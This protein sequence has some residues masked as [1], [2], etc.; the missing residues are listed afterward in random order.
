M[1]EEISIDFW[2]KP[3][4]S[5]FCWC[6]ARNCCSCS[7]S[8]PDS[9]R[10]CSSVSD[11]LDTARS[12]VSLMS[13][14]TPIS[15]GLRKPLGLA[16]S[17]GAGPSKR[18]A[19]RSAG[20]VQAFTACGAGA[21]GLPR[22]GDCIRK[23]TACIHGAGLGSAMLLGSWTSFRGEAGG[24]LRLPGSEAHES[25]TKAPFFE[26]F[27]A[28]IAVAKGRD[29]HDVGPQGKVAPLPLHAIILVEA[30]EDS[31]SKPFE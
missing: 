13:S 19:G 17:L 14:L 18:G 1:S 26:A 11:S 4:V 9:E 5:K 8:L 15:P 22:Q 24:L 12:T 27:E 6:L 23:V 25:H 20:S 2:S 28:Q 29:H 7:S 10:S 21:R 31:M 3:R 30:L 16:S